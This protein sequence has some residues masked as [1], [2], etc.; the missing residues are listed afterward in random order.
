[1]SITVTANEHSA[2]FPARSVAVQ[3]TVAIPTGNVLPEG[4]SQLTEPTPT[5]SV[6]VGGSQ[7]T[8][9]LH[10]PGSLSWVMSPGQVISGGW[11]SMI[12]CLP[13]VH[14]PLFPA[15]SRARIRQ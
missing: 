12:I 6:T 9:A 14:S 4:G 15:L 3:V 5:L 2:V 13:E 10:R 1:M 8:T 11:V 7:V